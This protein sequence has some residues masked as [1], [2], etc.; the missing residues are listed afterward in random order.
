MVFVNNMRYMRIKIFNLKIKI[1][2]HG[3]NKH[4]V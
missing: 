1:Q 4:F 2:K 3:V